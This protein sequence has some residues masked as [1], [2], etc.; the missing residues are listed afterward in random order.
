MVGRGTGNVQFSAFPLR[1]ARAAR[2]DLG[3]EVTHTGGTVMVQGQRM[4]ALFTRA[5]LGVITCLTLLLAGCQHAAPR[6]QAKADCSTLTQGLDQSGQIETLNLL[7]KAFSQ[8]C[9]DVVI[10]YGARAQT[11]YR[12]KTYSVIKETAS[13]FLPEGALTAYILESYERGYLTVLLADSYVQEKKAE[14]AKVE[15]RRLDQELF[16]PIYN[17]GED[18]VNLLLSAV[19]WEQLGDPGEARSEEHTSELQSR[20]HLVC[21]LLLEKKKN[22]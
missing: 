9:Y 13:I 19:L 17:Y 22:G 8:K 2:L 1:R 10:R 4:A 6:Q 14:A 12:H 11:E 18:P 20:L 15:L 3:G 7:A 5:G 21:R 16:A